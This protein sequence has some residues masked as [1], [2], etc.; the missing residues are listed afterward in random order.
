MYH[1]CT[2]AIEL[3][4]PG[5]VRKEISLIL[6][7]ETSG[8]VPSALNSVTT[9]SCT[10]VTMEYAA[11]LGQHH[12]TLCTDLQW[13]KIPVGAVIMIFMLL[14][15]SVGLVMLFVDRVEVTFFAVWK[16]GWQ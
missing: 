4:P 7:K 9:L 3:I 14:P 15:A 1:I 2:Y 16:R 5:I 10:T 6:L 11:T 8:I 13:Q 12:C